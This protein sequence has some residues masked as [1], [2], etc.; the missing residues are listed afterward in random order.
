MKTKGKKRY[1]VLGIAAGFLLSLGVQTY[2]Q[3]AVSTV[4][5]WIRNDYRIE[6]NG[7]EKKLPEGYQI[8][9]YQNRT[10]LPL[11]YVGELLGAD[12]QWDGETNTASI[13]QEKNPGIIDTTGYGILPQSVETLDYR[14]TATALMGKDDAEGARLYLGLKNKTDS[15]L[16]LDQGSTVFE[17]DGKEYTY[18]DVD[19]LLYD[20]RWYTTYLE[21]DAEAEGYLRLPKEAKEASQITITFH[22]TQDGN[23]EPIPV[24]FRLKLG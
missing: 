12:I 8:L 23:T 1:L 22:L 14:I 10:Y 20:S 16:R 18:R 4:A 21:K 2:A 17:I 19:S 3:D 24:T 6:Y 15:V 11:R 9:V 5:A 7:E 13:F